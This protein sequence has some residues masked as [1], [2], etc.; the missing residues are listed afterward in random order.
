MPYRAPYTGPNVCN[1]SRSLE[2]QANWNT[3]ILFYSI[4]HLRG[5][6]QDKNDRE[7]IAQIA[8]SHVCP[9][10]FHDLSANGSGCMILCIYNLNVNVV[11]TLFK[12]PWFF[13]PSCLKIASM[14]NWKRGNVENTR[15]EKYSRS[16]KAEWRR[17]LWCIDW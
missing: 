3:R 11:G 16:L 4:W 12:P 14:E 2:T 1:R 17:L 5:F 13:K 6:R 15:A 8:G 7:W 9:S 10:L